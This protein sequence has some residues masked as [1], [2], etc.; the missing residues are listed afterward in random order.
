MSPRS[1][2]APE[3][4]GARLLHLDC[5]GGATGESLLAALLGAGADPR[6]VRRALAAVW[7]GVRLRV[8]SAGDR[9]LP[10]TRVALGVSPGELTWKDLR[11][12]LGRAR[13]S[14]F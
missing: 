3:R 8:T 13:E 2:T 4:G 9:P 10:L 1:S 11:A 7:P 12:R 6:A 14:M 5:F